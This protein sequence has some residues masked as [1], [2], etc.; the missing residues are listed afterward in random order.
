M[1]WWLFWIIVAVVCFGYLINA[2]RGRKTYQRDTPLDIL[3]RR[4]A[5][6]EIDTEEY[7][8]RKRELEREDNL[9]P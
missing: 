6:G 5:A 1:I 2:S 8:L 7:N 9:K 4:Y 3:K